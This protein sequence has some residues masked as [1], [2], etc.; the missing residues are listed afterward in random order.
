[1][2]LA[3]LADIN[4]H[5]PEDR[6]AILDAE[7]EQWQV[8]VERAIKG[9]LAGTFSA[10]TLAGWSDP[11]ETDPNDPTYV[12]GLIRSIAGRFIAALFYRNK[13][14]E[15]TGEVSEY[16]QVLYDEAMSM[17][18]QIVSGELILS[19]ETEIVDTGQRLAREDFWPNDDTEPAP[20][21]NM[22]FGYHS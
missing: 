3:T 11:Q 20:L 1:M 13:V 17:L 14:S 12:P 19:D 2:A 18:R 4:V 16:P 6:L 22:E 15:V 5:L 8:N 9:Y 21:F 10:A 7:D